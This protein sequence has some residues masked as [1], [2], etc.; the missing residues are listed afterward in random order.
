LAAEDPKIGRYK[1]CNHVEALLAVFLV[2]GVAILSV[3]L[4]V[5]GAYCAITSLLAALNPS[6]NSKPL[7]ALVPSQ[8]SGD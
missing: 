1:G 4:G 3:A 8:A 2:S 5:F 6:R 7:P